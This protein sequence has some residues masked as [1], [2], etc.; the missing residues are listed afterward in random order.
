MH[1]AIDG[2]AAD[3]IIPVHNQYRSTR[4]LLESIYRHTDIPFHIYLIDNASTD[5]TVDLHKIYAR[6]ITVVRNHIH[7]SWRGS[8]NQG[9]RLGA[10]PYVVFMDN[11]IEVSQGW[12][13]NLTAFLD[14]HPRIGAV[15]PGTLYDP[16]AFQSQLRRLEE[17]YCEEGYFQ[18]RAGPPIVKI[19]SSDDVNPVSIVIPISEGP[20]FMVGEI[21]IKE[22]EVFPSATLLQMCPLSRGQPFK[23]RKL[24]DWMDA[25]KA[26]YREMGYIRF[27]VSSRAE[28]E[29]ARKI[30]NLTLDCREGKAYSVARIAVEG[31]PSINPSEF[32]K[33]LLLAEGGLFN[34][35]M[36][37][38]SLFYINRMRIYGSISESDVKIDIDDARLTVDLTFRLHPERPAT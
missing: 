17:M 22:T 3:L 19:Q 12:L 32:K 20:L 16:A 24:D 9:I 37:S 25:L 21:R 18:A 6:D 38:I 11:D 34:P 35:D 30:V 1:A 33:R 31:D 7:Q 8:I 14:T 36:I 10:S 28:T 13:G 15:G 5:E 29:D 23:Q 4:N 27:E 2:R 26:S